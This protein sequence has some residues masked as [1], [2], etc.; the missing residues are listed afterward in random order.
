MR[1]AAIDA[2]A[3]LFPGSGAHALEVTMLEIDA[4]ASA[5]L[6]AEAHLD[7]GAHG[8]PRVRLPFGADL[9]GDHQ[10]L[11]RLPHAH[12]SDDHVGSILVARVPAATDE[13]LDVRLG[14]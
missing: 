11:G 7:L 9:P 3:H 10:S 14:N 5:R 4:G 12:V 13:G 6:G 8:R 2:V 1:P